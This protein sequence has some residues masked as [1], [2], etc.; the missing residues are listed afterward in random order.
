MNWVLLI[1]RVV[2]GGYF[3]YNGINH[4]T[5]MKMMAAHAA[6]HGVPGVMIP[7]TGAMLLI[8]GLHLLLG[9]M[10]RFG[11]S[12]LV[13]FLIPVTVIMHAFW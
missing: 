9:V 12:M 7:L 10:P 13:A 8:G 1:G 3:F 5:H 6:E 2:F 11:L 4:F